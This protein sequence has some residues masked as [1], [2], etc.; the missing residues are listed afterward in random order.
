M[1]LPPVVV[2][3]KYAADFLSD[4]R[5]MAAFGNGQVTAGCHHHA[6]KGREDFFDAF[7]IVVSNAEIA[8]LP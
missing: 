3:E 8:L 2:S 6:K 1:N 7:F 5:Q 4:P